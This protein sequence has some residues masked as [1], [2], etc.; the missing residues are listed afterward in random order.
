MSV[1][2]N[3]YKMSKKSD[4]TATPAGQ[5][6]SPTATVSGEFRAPWDILQ[7]VVIVE[8][9]KV[10]GSSVFTR[11]EPVNYAQIYT[12]ASDRNRLYWISDIVWISDKL[13]ELHLVED[14]L[15]TWSAEIRSGYQYALRSYSQ[16]DDYLPDDLCPVSGQQNLTSSDI[17]SSVPW[18]GVEPVNGYYVIGVISDGFSPQG[19]T[20]YYR[21]DADAFEDFR[22]QMLSS[23]SWTGMTFVD[24]EQD[25]YKSLF[26]PFQYITSCMWFPIC[27]DANVGGGVSSVP[28][29]WWD[30]P[31]TGSNLAYPIAHATYGDNI[32]SFCSLSHHWQYSTHKNWLDGP[33]Y[34]QASLYLQPFGTIPIDT[35]LFVHGTTQGIDASYR[36]DYITGQC[37]LRLYKHSTNIVVADQ[38]SQIGVPVLVAQA[39]QDFIGAVSYARDAVH[40]ASK[41]ARGLL[42]GAAGYF[43]GNTGAM[44]QGMGRLA[45]GI[46]D[47]AV[48]VG[49]AATAFAPTIAST[50]ADG[51]FLYTGMRSYV[52][53]V[54]QSVNPVEYT[55]FG[56]P[57]CHV[58]NMA[59]I[60]GFVKCGNAHVKFNGPNQMERNII[61]AR[62]NSGCVLEA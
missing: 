18:W 41:A 54:A 56:Y 46:V 16:P 60:T 5:N 53:T 40:G 44:L 42:G 23:T 15:G 58:V 20:C 45:D 32:T 3:L 47:T 14:P 4:S 51:S 11:S 8:D 29:G 34:R 7:P 19:S 39:T 21:L 38:I 22:E 57:C 26:N 35:S 1:T 50:G 33:P 13:L 31:L 52:N 62:L 24:L 9:I 2:L 36:I 43:T 28:L 10:G 48:G 17:S 49:S 6:I 61:E 12:G 37:Q 27:P 25:L 59:N 55:D 30:L